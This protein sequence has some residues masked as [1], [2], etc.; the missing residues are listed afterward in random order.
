[1]KESLTQIGLEQPAA[2]QEA[3]SIVREE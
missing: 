3:V 1:L 2:F